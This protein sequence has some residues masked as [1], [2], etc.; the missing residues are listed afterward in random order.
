MVLKAILG[1][2]IS[3]VRKITIFFRYLDNV[4][5]TGSYPQQKT[6][7]NI[8]LL[9]TSTPHVTKKGLPKSQFYR[10]GRRSPTQQDNTDLRWK[11]NFSLGVS[12]SFGLSKCLMIHLCC[13]NLVL[14]KGKKLSDIS[15]GQAYL[16]MSILYTCFDL[17]IGLLKRCTLE[18]AMYQKFM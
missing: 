3:S 2:C 14:T 18:I 13:I 7:R 4:K 5:I 8:V 16:Q 6:D 17:Y 9:A 1:L 15:F 10:L 12:N 11:Q